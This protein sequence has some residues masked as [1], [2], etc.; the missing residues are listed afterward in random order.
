M[1]LAIAVKMAH[2]GDAC[3]VQP[4]RSRVSAE[5]MRGPCLHEKC[6]LLLVTESCW[7]ATHAVPETSAL[8]R[9]REEFAGS[10]L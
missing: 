4:R 10:A 1:I 7:H 8:P 6:D 9:E 2:A 3:W 5:A